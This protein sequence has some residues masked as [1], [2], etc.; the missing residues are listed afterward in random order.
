M[1]FYRRYDQ[2]WNRAGWTRAPQYSGQAA[3]THDIAERCECGAKPSR[4]AG[5]TMFCEAGCRMPLRP[6]AEMVAA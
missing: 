4:F 5:G 6:I 1:T 2:G 3:M